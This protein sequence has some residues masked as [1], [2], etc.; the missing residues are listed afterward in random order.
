MDTG[1]GYATNVI[2]REGSAVPGLAGV[3]FN[4]FDFDDRAINT[5]GQVAFTGDMIGTGVVTTASATGNNNAIFMTN[6]V[7]NLYLVAREN[8]NVSI[9]AVAAVT[10]FVTGPQ[11]V[12]LGGTGSSVGFDD[13]KLS[14]SGWLAFND[15]LRAATGTSGTASFEALFVVSV[16]S[17]GAVTRKTVYVENDANTFSA[18]ALGLL[19][20]YDKFIRSSSDNGAFLIDGAGRVLF[21]TGVG[22]IG[23]TS[24]TNAGWYLFDPT[25]DGRYKVIVPGDEI[26]V[27]GLP[28]T[29]ATVSKPNDD[30]EGG[31]DGSIR[32][33]N[34]DGTMV[35]RLTFTDGTVGL[36]T[37]DVDAA[38]PTASSKWGVNASGDW[39]VPG[40]WIGGVP[41]TVG[42]EANFTDAITAPRIVNVDGV[43]TVGKM[44]F[45]NNTAV[46][47]DTESYTLS[48]AG[49]IVLDA[50]TGS[51]FIGVDSGNHTIS[52]T[53]SLVDNVGLQVDAGSTL[54]LA[55]NLIGAG[56][57]TKAGPGTLALAGT[58]NSTGTLVISGGSVT[59]TSGAALGSGMV[60][61]DG[62]QFLS[63]GNATLAND[64]AFTDK[65]RA[66]L[67]NGGFNIA[68]SHI[69]TLTGAF[70]TIE[71]GD[72]AA[73]DDAFFYKTGTGK[74]VLAGTGGT[75][76]FTV[77]A[78]SV[79]VT[80]NY[81]FG[82]GATAST[83][84]VARDAQLT[85]ATGGSL[86][87]AG[88]VLLSSGSLP[89][90]V[91]GTAIV[92]TLTL[93]TSNSGGVFTS[94]AVV[95]GA[96]T[97]NGTLQ[98]GSTT[99]GTV[100]QGS[101]LANPGS[102]LNVG[103]L[104]VRGPTTLAGTATIGE[105]QLENNGQHFGVLN[106][107]AD[108]TV[109]GDFTITGTTNPT[110]SATGQYIAA[111]GVTVSVG[112]NFSIESRTTVTL[113]GTID[114]TGNAVVDVDGT[115]DAIDATVTGV[116]DAAATSVAAEYTTSGATASGVLRIGST[117]TL[118]TGA[119]TISSNRS[120]TSSATTQVANTVTVGLEVS[121]VANAGLV[122]MFG[123]EGFLD[124]NNAVHTLSVAST[125]TL[126]A[127][128]I[129]VFSTT[130]GVTNA[131]ADVGT[132]N[133]NIAGQVNI[134]PIA[135]G[136]VTSLLNAAPTI[137]G[138]GQ[139]NLADTSMA[140]NWAGSDPSATLLGLV[141]SGFNGGAWDGP[142]IVGSGDYLVALPANTTADLGSG[143]VNVFGL[144]FGLGSDTF[145]GVL[146]D[147]VSF[148]ITPR[149]AGD[150]D[151]DGDVEFDDLG[152]LLGAYDG[153]G[154]VFDGDSTY[155]GLVDFNDLGRL[156]GNYG[157]GIPGAVVGELDA[158]AV[159]LLVSA[160]FIAV[161]EP[162]TAL[163][164]MA[165]MGLLAA[166]RR[167]R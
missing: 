65:V 167:R 165:G 133:V 116:L 123:N 42:A 157:I 64:F 14:D 34:D 6:S 98:V 9:D 91:D 162:S 141:V 23:S 104:E 22:E 53:V 79:E 19:G 57:L 151:L 147:S 2:A 32:V 110:P 46:L 44:Y 88:T 108:T 73:V 70:S 33:L 99:S 158:A 154:T 161:P 143:P 97:V 138:T 149:P 26:L 155:D 24:S 77:S 113:G 59:A 74:L 122:S 56:D 115:N 163:V 146:V 140:V 49:T 62:G 153:A 75:A 13:I 51:A 60:T 156:L 125:G 5:S 10:G 47:P 105:L 87:H 83:M 118:N 134:S 120:S 135:D 152:R 63:T 4:A 136:G 130:G 128:G 17:L 31:E 159:D 68:G 11:T 21:Y 41:N 92:N 72:S 148:I 85:V 96:L 131:E 93:S 61:M 55:G 164:G 109:T 90:V 50:A 15:R 38:V 103:L 150:T 52:S 37:I 111:P 20:N 1:A 12:R 40:N 30:T 71:T 54:T 95:N 80:G 144:D 45:N 139:I 145:E 18:A 16:D 27:D 132:Y 137:T 43:F 3:T 29:V 67:G 35:V 101:L 106:V 84:T 66:T 107:N 112:G 48:G 166:R 76:G 100:A 58:N 124:R 86:S 127:D 39:S 78:G 129:R 36:Y 142:G 126:N 89:F 117:G 82:T 121:G 94:S 7:G 119:L 102:V 28:K 81:A 69:V 8:D 114:V 25:T 160:G